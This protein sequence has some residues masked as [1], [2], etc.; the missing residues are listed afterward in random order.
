MLIPRKGLSQ[1]EFDKR[2]KEIDYWE[3]MPSA[4]DAYL[5]ANEKSAYVRIAEEREALGLTPEE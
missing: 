3:N 1:A 5:D 4:R 2:M